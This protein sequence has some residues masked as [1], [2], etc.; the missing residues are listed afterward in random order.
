MASTIGKSFITAFFIMV[1]PA[2][3]MYF[4]FVLQITE[5]FCNLPIVFH[6]TLHESV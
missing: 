5:I 1:N 3:F 6:Q 4:S 2:I